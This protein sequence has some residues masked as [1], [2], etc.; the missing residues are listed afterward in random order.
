MAIVRDIC[1]PIAGILI[2]SAAN[3]GFVMRGPLVVL[4]RRAFAGPRDA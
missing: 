1:A 4:A 2:R 3:I